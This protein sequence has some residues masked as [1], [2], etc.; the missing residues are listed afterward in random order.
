[1][2]R[3]KIK[4]F[5]KLA[6]SDLRKKA[7]KIIEAGLEAIDTKKA[8]N[9]QI[10]LKKDNLIVKNKKI[11][12]KGIKRIFV[13]GIGKCS[14]DAAAVLEKKLKSR[15]SGG[16][17][18]DIK[19]GRLKKIKAYFGSHPLMSRRNVDATK[20]II[21]LLSNLKKDNLVIF[22]I[23]GGGS[24]LLSQP[25]NFTFREEFAIVG[26]LLQ[27]GADIKEINT[28]RKHLSLA[29]GGYLTKYAYPAKVISLIFSDVIGSNLEFV[30]SGPTMKDTTTLSEAESVLKKYNI[31]EK[32]G[33]PPIKL[34]ETP[35]EEKYFKKV[36]NILLLSNNTAL[37]AMKNEARSNGFK[38]KIMTNRLSGKAKDVATEIV[39]KLANEPSK[40]AL[41]FGGETT[42]IV[43]GNG[44]GG[45][46]QE[47][48]L[49]ALKYI[50][51]NQLIISISSDGRDNTDHAGGICDIITKEKA[52][53]K[54]LDIKKY[55][56]NNDSYSFFKKTGDYLKTGDTGSNVSDLIIAIKE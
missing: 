40:T 5:N 28:V 41:I 25:Q 13:V 49:T 7:L 12:L 34:I 26:H 35:K 46:N 24:A 44:K 33:F 56:E 10:F 18:L 36:K 50:K 23:S 19:K 4:N 31:W 51:E 3:G 48:S 55:L 52:K 38:T 54:E 37:E 29:R 47:L 1:M 14:L 45:R 43:K 27:S 53:K 22:V 6:V 16:I 8:I 2:Y 17:V 32:C 42:V 20:K 9:K 39:E 15:L 11:S 30:A 21:K